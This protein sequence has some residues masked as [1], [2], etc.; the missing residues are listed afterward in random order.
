ML[1]QVP[2]VEVAEAGLKL[3]SYFPSAP[4]RQAS[5]PLVLE[6]SDGGRT[7]QCPVHITEA[8]ACLFVCLFVKQTG[9]GNV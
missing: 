5:S 9:E 6:G 8:S 2:Q 4:L 3:V 7:P 1:A